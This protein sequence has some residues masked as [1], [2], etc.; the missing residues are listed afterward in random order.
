MREILRVPGSIHEYLWPSA[1]QVPGDLQP[2]SALLQTF[3]CSAIIGPLLQFA[4]LSSEAVAFTC[5]TLRM[6]I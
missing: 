3:H 5:Y 1:P 4:D 6:L 2:L